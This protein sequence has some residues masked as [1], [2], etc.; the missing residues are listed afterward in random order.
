[1][2]GSIGIDGSLAGE[3]G[4]GLSWFKAWKLRLD[5]IITTKGIYPLG[6]SYKLDGIG[7][8]NSAVGIAVGTGYDDF[9]SDKRVM[10]YFSIKF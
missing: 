2:G 8:D 10:A 6:V 1:V 3:A 7:L 9:L 4:I 5:S